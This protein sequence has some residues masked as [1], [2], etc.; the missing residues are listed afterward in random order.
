MKKFYLTGGFKIK[1]LL[2]VPVILA[3]FFVS[4]P[5]VNAGNIKDQS[6]A[7]LLYRGTSRILT[8]PMRGASTAINQSTRQP[9]PFGLVAGTLNGTVQ[10]VA[11]VLSGAI[12]LARGAVPYAKYLVFFI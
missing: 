4:T 7:G 6:T 5:S 2:F 11:G 9:F 8:A 12:D 10:T 3:F 1:A